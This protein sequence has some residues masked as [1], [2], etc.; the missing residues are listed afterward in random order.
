MILLGPYIEGAADGIAVT[1]ASGF[2][3]QPDRLRQPR[4]DH[5]V[6]AAKERG[7]VISFGEFSRA[8]VPIAILSLA[9]AFAWVMLAVS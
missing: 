5:R 6:E 7:I 2:S 4:H 3:S 8:G 9:F 1:L